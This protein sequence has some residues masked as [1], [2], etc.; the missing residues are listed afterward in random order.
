MPCNNYHKLSSFTA[1]MTYSA[2]L[3]Y[4]HKSNLMKVIFSL[5]QKALMTTC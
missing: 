5:N 4:M 1:Y 3:I 2:E